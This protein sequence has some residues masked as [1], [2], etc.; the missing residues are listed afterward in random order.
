MAENRVLAEAADLA[1]D[2]RHAV[3]MFVRAVRD[4]TGTPRTVRSDTLELLEREGALNVARLAEL[5][6]V[7]HQSMRLVT[8]QLDAE[9]LVERQANG[10]DRRSQLFVITPAGLDWLKEARGRRAE[11]IRRRIESR[12]SPR[13]LEDLRRAAGLLRRLAERESAD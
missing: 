8:A 2:L 11:S 13:D 3:H 5:R 7:K 4:E 12:L 6:N 10:A 1:E 9:G